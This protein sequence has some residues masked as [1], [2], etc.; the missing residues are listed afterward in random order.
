MKPFEM[1]LRTHK[2]DS[3]VAKDTLPQGLLYAHKAEGFYA[4]K[5]TLHPVESVNTEVV[6]TDNPVQLL[7]ENHQDNYISLMKK[8]EGA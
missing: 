8:A 1:A 6:N 4:N 3:N 7:R 2:T 5:Y